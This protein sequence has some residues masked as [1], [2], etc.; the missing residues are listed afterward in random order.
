LRSGEE[1]TAELDGNHMHQ[2]I[3]R[4][5]EALGGTVAKQPRKPLLLGST[6]GVTA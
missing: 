2:R 1:A 6:T 4:Q 5:P 3:R